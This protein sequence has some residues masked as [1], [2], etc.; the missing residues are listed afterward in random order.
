MVPQEN[1]DWHKKFD[2]YNL[3]IHVE[4]DEIWRGK[5]W[6]NNIESCRIQWGAKCSGWKGGDANLHEEKID[7]FNYDDGG[8]KPNSQCNSWTP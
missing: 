4:I 3:F 6:E 5:D 1:I 2:E 8:H 7:I